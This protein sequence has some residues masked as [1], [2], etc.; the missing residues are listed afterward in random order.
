[1]EGE[2]FEVYEIDERGGAWVTK[3]WYL[4]D[5]ES[6]SHSLSRASDEMEVAASA[7]TRDA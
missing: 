1:M 2:V 7:Q 5:G 4:T 6:F 3:W